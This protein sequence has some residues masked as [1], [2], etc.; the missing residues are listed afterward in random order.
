MNLKI[1]KAVLYN[2]DGTVNHVFNDAKF[3]EVISPIESQDHTDKALFL[4]SSKEYEV[5][6]EIDNI[7]EDVLYQLGVI[8][9]YDWWNK[10][11]VNVAFV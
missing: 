11:R 4:S 8:H 7:N 1:I 2:K 9:W 6:F 5:S 10:E 3:D